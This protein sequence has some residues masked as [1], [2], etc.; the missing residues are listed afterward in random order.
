MDVSDFVGSCIRVIDSKLEDVFTDSGLSGDLLAAASY[1]VLGGGKRIRP[2]LALAVA[3]D[4]GAAVE[5]SVLPV[6]A[7]ELVHCSSLIHDDLPGID[8]DDMRRGRPSCHKAFTE[9]TAILAGDALIPIANELILKA[10][11]SDRKKVQLSAELSLAFREI[12]SGQQLD[13]ENPKALPERKVMYRKKT[14]ALFGCSVT[15]GALVSPVELSR[16]T[17]EVLREAGIHLGY[18]FQILDDMLD[19]ESMAAEKGRSISS[20]LRND[21]V[22]L[23]SNLSIAE[24]EF[25]SS[26]EHFLRGVQLS[27]VS[28]TESYTCALAG[29]LSGK[30]RGTVSELRKLDLKR[31]EVQ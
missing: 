3:R 26:M 21:K 5:A 11:V 15:F 1:S 19:D 16:E 14:G 17:T 10:E 9:A 30:F 29:L 23:R 22:T 6:L 24:A 27:G 25:N 18:C 20:D 12:C 31:G 28:G 4:F 13:L 2:T 8:N 7:I